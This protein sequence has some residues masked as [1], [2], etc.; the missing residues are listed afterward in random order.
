VGSQL[1][2]DAPPTVRP[3]VVTDQI[4]ELS[5]LYEMRPNMSALQFEIH[6]PRSRAGLLD[7]T[8]SGRM[9][10]VDLTSPP[11]QRT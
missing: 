10:T 2:V 6:M 8:T 11:R 9:A 1:V 4:V 5:R 3:R 7:V